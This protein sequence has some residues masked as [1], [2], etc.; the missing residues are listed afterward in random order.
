MCVCGR[1]FVGFG[2]RSILICFGLSLLGI[3]VDVL[4]A[5]VSSDN[6]CNRNRY[7]EDLGGSFEA[8]LLE[9]HG[10]ILP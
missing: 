7:F 2:Y 8:V 1:T 4:P 6:F 10:Q 3:L 5:V 9:H